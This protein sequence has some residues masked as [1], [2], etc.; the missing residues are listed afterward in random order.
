MRYP[1]R[2]GR[3]TPPLWLPQVRLRS[4]RAPW[5]AGEMGRAAVAERAE[6]VDQVMVVERVAAQAELAPAAAAAGAPAPALAERS[7]SV[8]SSRSSNGSPPRLVAASRPHVQSTASGQNSLE[9]P[10]GHLGPSVDPSVLRLLVELPIGPPAGPRCDRNPPRRPEE[11]SSTEARLAV[12]ASP[13]RAR[14]LFT[15]R[16]AISSAVSS[17]RPCSRRPSLMCSY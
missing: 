15:V 6:V 14:S 13:E 10:F 17:E 5:G 11:M 9:L 4:P 8:R 16:A 3:Q 1:R 12:R 7:A 2:L